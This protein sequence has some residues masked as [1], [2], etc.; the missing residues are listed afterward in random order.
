[1]KKLVTSKPFIAGSLAVLCVAI[2]AVCLLWNNGVTN[3]FVPDPTLTADPI[4]SWTENTVPSAGS[5]ESVSH[6]PAWQPSG[7]QAWQ[8]SG[9]QSA[10]DSDEFPRIVEENKDKNEVIIQFSDTEQIRE[11]PPDEA[12]TDQKDMPSQQPAEAE[13][14]RSDPPADTP[15]A[16]STNDKGEVYDPVFG[17]VKPSQVEQKD[18]NSSGDPNKIIGNMN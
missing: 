12:G 13:K 9:G 8:P 18:D 16:G 10:K 11:A 14:S 2:L 6:N 1:M 5:A 15:K 3:P 7:G 4:D 17:W